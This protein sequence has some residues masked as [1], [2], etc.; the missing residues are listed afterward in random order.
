MMKTWIILVLRE[1][2]EWTQIAF[3]APQPHTR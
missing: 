3:N 2:D 1:L